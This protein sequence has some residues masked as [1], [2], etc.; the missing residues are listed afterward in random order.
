M[1]KNKE[2]IKEI[3]SFIISTTILCAAVNLTIGL[4]VVAGESMMPTLENGSLFVSFRLASN[5]ERGDIVVVK[6]HAFKEHIVKRVI[7]LPG[8]TIR[9]EGKDVYINDELLEENY[10]QHVDGSSEEKFTQRPIEITLG[11][12]EYFVIGDNRDR[13]SDSREIGPVTKKEIK[14]KKLL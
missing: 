8:E 4:N 5:F 9:I 6:S 11:E 7:G 3:V 10:T 14:G 2:L 13:S 12:D 1:R